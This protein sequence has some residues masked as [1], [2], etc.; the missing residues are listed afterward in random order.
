VNSQSTSQAERI[1]AAAKATPR[2][3]AEAF[4]FVAEC[5]DAVHRR[6]GGK[7]PNAPPVD[8]LRTVVDAAANAWGL[9]G[10]AVLR[11]WGLRTTLDVGH[12]C[13]ALIDAQAFRWRGGESVAD[14]GGGCDLPGAVENL[15][16]NHL[17]QVVT[18]WSRAT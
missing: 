4:G 9:M 11:C 17:H 5:I 8:V 16:K 15:A 14:F 12:V 3:G 18:A 13:A 2:Y 7:S 6:V 1:A 10:G